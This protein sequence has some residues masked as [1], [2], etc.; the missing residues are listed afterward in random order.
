[1]LFK[2]V[3]TLEPD[4]KSRILSQARHFEIQLAKVDFWEDLIIKTVAFV[5][6]TI[7]GIVFIIAPLIVAHWVDLHLSANWLIAYFLLYQLAA[8]I[9]YGLILALPAYFASKTLVP[10]IWFGIV[11]IACSIALY[12]IYS[13]I[14][15]SPPNI[16]T[17]FH[18]SIML[19]GICAIS[20]FFIFLVLAVFIR[21]ISR[22]GRNARYPDAALADELLQ[23]VVMVKSKPRQWRNL[24]FKRRLMNKLEDAASCVQRN[25]PRRLRSGDVG[26][27]VWI[28]KTADEIAA[29]LRA[30]KKSLLTAKP[31]FRSQFLAQITTN[32]VHAFSGNWDDM[33]KAEPKKISLSQSWRARVVE[34]FRVSLTGGIPLL[35]VWGIQQTPLALQGALF[36]TVTIVAIIW[37]ILTLLAAFDPLYSAKIIS[38]K[39]I[40]PFLPLPIK[41]RK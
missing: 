30:Q 1:M 26:T 36:E 22:K 14:G 38:L 6:V 3:Q 29:A 7:A 10:L 39:D 27:D 5:I 8:V 12:H 40:A 32:L 37:A 33:D 4:I 2:Y 28:A 18:A 15:T 9:A 17:S 24:A 41:G 25:L 35:M 19:G 13:A 31:H 23:I 11:L 21:F 16:F 34:V 20:A